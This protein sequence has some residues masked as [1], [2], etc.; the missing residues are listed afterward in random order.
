M[1]QAKSSLSERNGYA[2]MRSGWIGASRVVLVDR[3]LPP[4]QE[5]KTHY[6]GEAAL[7]LCIV[8]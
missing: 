3:D 4:M 1:L 8:F 2:R 6:I 7:R 5:D